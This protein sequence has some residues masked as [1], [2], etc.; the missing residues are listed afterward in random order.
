[1]KIRS[2]AM[3]GGEIPARF[4]KYGTEKNSYGIPSISIPF[5]I[6]DAPEGTK[7]YALVLDDAD[8]V[9]VCGFVWIHWIAANIK[10]TE[11]PENDSQN[12]DYVQGTNSWLQTYG[13]AGAV[14]YGG[15]TPPDAPHTYTLRVYALDTVLDLKEGFFLNELLHGMKGHVLGTAEAEGFYQN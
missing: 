4:G 9:P 7:S 13:K 15:M 2:E 14:G 10:K 1:M 11:I 3:N 5:T 6:E 12:A 8:A